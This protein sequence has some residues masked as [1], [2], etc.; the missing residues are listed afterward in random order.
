MQYNF[1]AIIS[2]EN[3]CSEKFD[4]RK[5]IFGRP[6]VI[7]MWVAD[8][9]FATMPEIIEAMK[10]RLEHPIMGYSYRSKSYDNSII[11]WVKR[12]NRWD[13]KPE[14]LDFTPGVVPGVVFA[15]R[16]FTS[17]GEGVLIQPPVYHPFARQ[18]KL[19]DRFVINNPVR[20]RNGS[21]EID[22]EDLD[23]KLTKA[24]TFIL[25]NPHNPTG[26]VF[27][28]DELR[29]MGELCVKHDVIIL[30]DEIHS[31]IIQAPHKHI[32]IA[33]LDKRFA[34]RTITF[35]AP[36]KTFNLAGLSTAVS[37]ASNDTL[38]RQ[39]HYEYS[40][41]HCDQGNIFGAIA[42][43]TA[44]T[45]GDEWV[46]QMNNYIGRNMDYVIDYLKKNIP[47]VK[48]NK[49]EG[50]YLMWLDFRSWGIPHEELN[51][52]IINKARLGLNEGS[53]FGIEGRGFMRM[54]VATQL[55]TVERAMKQLHD[56]VL[57][58]R[59]ELCKL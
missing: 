10:K 24:K 16:A 58:Y 35:I 30:A 25:C 54:N 51:Q 34:E 50:T 44:Y 39:L 27:T 22:F 40:K 59:P 9:D 14:W 1:D 13:I 43:E 42:L 32:H 23:Q 41:L 20:E 38:Y 12:H 19:N 8:M 17:A 3:S 18:T 52:F 37:I 2:R 57:A 4:Y 26:R 33:S 11:Q 29:R 49:P 47:S 6:D 56:A 55:A 53:M 36:S 31:D 46:K 28:E 21:F 45:K 48:C 15:I 7:P 5:K